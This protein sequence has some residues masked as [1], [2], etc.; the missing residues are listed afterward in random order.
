[1]PATS[2]ALLRALKL[3]Y[4]QTVQ[5]ILSRKDKLPTGK[6]AGVID[7]MVGLLEAEDLARRHKL[8]V[9]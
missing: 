2:L 8:T 5:A 9:A 7:C 6:E 3:A 4:E 1:M